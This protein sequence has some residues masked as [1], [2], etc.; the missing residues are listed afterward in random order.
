MVINQCSVR[1]LLLAGGFAALIA[2]APAAVAQ[3]CG[4]TIAAGTRTL[5]DTS[6]FDA[7]GTS[8]CTVNKTNGSYSLACSVSSM[9]NNGGSTPSE[10]GLTQQNTTRGH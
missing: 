2:I 5:A 8:S 7:S 6:S 3:C 9:Q 1:R 10:L 4:P